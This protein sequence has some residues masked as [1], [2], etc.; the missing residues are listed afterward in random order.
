MGSKKTNRSIFDN[1]P[2]LRIEQESN[3]KRVSDSDVD[4]DALLNEPIPENDC[5]PIQLTA[6]VKRQYAGYQH[7]GK[8]CALFEYRMGIVL[9]REKSNKNHGEWENHI[10]SEYPF[11]SR[12]AS[13]YMRIARLSNEDE[14]SSMTANALKE[15]HGIIQYRKD[16]E[17]PTDAWEDGQDNGPED[18][19]MAD[20][21]S[22]GNV[23]KKLADASRALCQKVD[24]LPPDSY[25]SPERHGAFLKGFVTD[26]EGAAR[27]QLRAIM[28]MLSMAEEATEGALANIREDLHRLEDRLILLADAKMERD[29]SWQSLPVDPKPLG[30]EFT[31]DDC[32]QVEDFP[33]PE[34]F[35]CRRVHDWS[36]GGP[37][38]LCPECL[39][40]WIDQH[41]VEE[42]VEVEEEQEEAA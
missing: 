27:N 39:D 16:P 7:L 23:V 17:P 36:V 37:R 3:R 29:D 31:C 33:F 25:N 32:G 42:V 21:E 40:T 18:D 14:A 8:K 12:T 20:L 28:R 5:E 15:K 11:S 10:E 19:G 4:I 1:S 41:Y 34:V 30:I 22:L 13:T 24:S 6:F 9:I 35:K 38:T 2:T 26:I